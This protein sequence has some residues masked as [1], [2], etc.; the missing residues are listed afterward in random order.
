MRQDIDVHVPARQQEIR[1]ADEGRRNQAVGN[2]V[3]LPDS[4]LIEDVA[5]EHHLADDDHRSGDQACGNNTAQLRDHCDGAYETI[6]V[7]AGTKVTAGR[8]RG[9][10]PPVPSGSSY[11]TASARSISFWPFGTSL[12]NSL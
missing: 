9:V 8:R 5:E 6:L 2:E 3:G 4:S 7:R 11:L 10:A 12:A 1:T